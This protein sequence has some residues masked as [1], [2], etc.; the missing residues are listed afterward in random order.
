M[1][2]FARAVRNR[3]EMTSGRSGKRA[4]AMSAQRLF[5]ARVKNRCECAAAVTVVLNRPNSG[6]NFSQ[7]ASCMICILRIVRSVQDQVLPC[8]IACLQ[9]NSVRA[10]HFVIE[11]RHFL[12][13]S[14]RAGFARFP[15]LCHGRACGVRWRR[16]K[17]NAAR[18]RSRADR[19][20][21][22]THRTPPNGIAAPVH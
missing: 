2:G 19:G 5:S 22:D 8:K 7:A 17:P 16:I 13:I 4:I 18:R 3:L 14:M 10:S 15:V 1:S 21:D 6:C 20:S 9:W 12:S 11:R